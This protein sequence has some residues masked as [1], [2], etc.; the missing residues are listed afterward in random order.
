MASNVPTQARIEPTNK[1]NANE[2]FNT[3]GINMSTAINIF[4]RQCLLHGGFS[5][6]V[7][8]PN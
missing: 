4:L 6:E 8:I 3:L 7:K 2:L 1:K 5:F